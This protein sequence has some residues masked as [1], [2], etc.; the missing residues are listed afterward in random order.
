MDALDNMMANLHDTQT[1]Y[2]LAMVAILVATVVLWLIMMVWGFVLEQ[3]SWR[4]RFI[5]YDELLGHRVTK[6]LRGMD[7]DDSEQGIDHETR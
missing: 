6:D 5:P 4:D 2:A 7:D 1:V 3:K